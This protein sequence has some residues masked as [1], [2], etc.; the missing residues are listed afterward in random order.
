[1]RS[2]HRLLARIALLLLAGVLLADAPIATSRASSAAAAPAAI[3]GLGAAAEVVTD[4]YGI[5]HVRA[6]TLADAYAAWG[7]VTARDRGWQLVLSRAQAQG[8]TH[9]W[10]GN[11]ALQAD[12][13]AQLFRLHERAVAIWERERADADVRTALE[14]FARGVNSYFADCRAG[15]RPWPPEVQRLGIT[16]EDWKPED[17][18][19]LLL[20]FGITLDLALPEA[21]EAKAIEKHGVEWVLQRRR[22]EDAWGYSSVPDMATAPRKIAERAAA[23]VPPTRLPEAVVAAT[24]R[25]VAQWP[26]ADAD[27]ATRASNEFAVGGGRTASGAPIVANDPHLALEAP[28]PFYA[29]HVSVPG[30]VDAAGACVPGLPIVVSGHNA[31]AAWGVTALSIDV[32]DLYAD[33]LDAAGTHVR[34]RSGW[35]PVTTAPYD[36]HYRVLGLSIPVPAF[37]QQRRYGPHGPIVNFDRKHHLAVA[38]RWS[39]FEDARITLRGLVGIE[40]ATSAAE[41]TTRA[42]RLV[43]PTLN[44]VAADASGDVRYRACGLL[45]HRPYAYTPGL[46]P[47]DGAHEWAGYVAADSMP[48]WQVPRDA[49]VVNANNRPAGAAYAERLDR[50]DWAADRARRIAAR[51]AGDASMTLADAVSVQNDTY[52]SASARQLPALMHAVETLNS[53]QPRE[54]AALDSLR[55]WDFLARRGRVAPTIARAWWNVYVRRARLDGLPGL[56]LAALEGRAPEALLA[57]GTETREAPTVAARAAL[58]AALDSLT[59]QLGPD[60]STWRYGRVHRARFTH[61]LS[62]LDGRKRWEPAATPVDGD[63]STPC[64]GAA[65]MPYRSEVTH[66]PAWRMVVDLAHPDSALVVLPPWNSADSRIALLPDWADHRPVPLLTSWPR[67]LATARER[68]TLTPR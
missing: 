44:F 64:V 45:P 63:G 52:S 2:P 20:G 50:F 39:A 58:D 25:A 38:L 49:F 21:S 31:Q 9:R 4:P 13:G 43:T 61:A 15:R 57:P 3:A 29:V 51:L 26:G 16:P 40:R 12:G 30:T 59:R 14:A 34:F 62:D 41:I 67:V 18:V 54:L 48:Q 19:A 28:S 17:S 42:S 35:A 68:V 66:G 36:L 56:A 47:G 33:T 27:G 65:S 37:V 32:V 10:L 60:M 55:R 6:A 11:D 23:A 53:L 8:Q 22:F 5:P 46:L 7:W 1:M 24:A